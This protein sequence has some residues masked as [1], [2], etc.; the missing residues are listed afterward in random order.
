MTA[1]LTANITATSTPSTHLL[2]QLVLLGGGPAHVHLLAHL[3]RL[4]QNHWPGV[5]VTLVTPTQQLM[6]TG[7]LAGFVSGQRAL[8]DCVIPLEPL[9]QRSGMRW[10]AARAVELD[11]EAH[12]V[13]LDDNSVLHFDWLSLCNEPLQDRDVIERALPGARKNGLFVRPLDAFCALWP[14]VAELAASR[15]LRVAVIGGEIDEGMKGVNWVKGVNGVKQGAGRVGSGDAFAIELA[16]A[17]RHRLPGAAVTLITGG[18]PLATA[19]APAV[20]KRIARALRQRNVTVLADTATRILSGSI[21]LGCGA[22]LACDVP[23]IATV[24]QAPAWLANSGLALDAQGFIAVDAGQRCVS[25]ANI[26][27][28]GQPVAA[29]SADAADDDF[30]RAGQALV[31]GLEASL[32]AGATGGPARGTP[33]RRLLAQPPKLL[34]CCDGHAIA[35]WY[36]HGAQGRWVN[37]LKNRMDQSLV[38]RYRDI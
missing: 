2:K 21:L 3:G 38:A 11:A 33:G 20:Q 13:L 15:A 10:Q 26:F 5:Q 29:S 37:W 23:V 35:S 32:A 25:H 18:A 1:T 36:G 7:L 28:A 16:L 30:D 27:V 6:C 4:G 31:S 14:R 22:R 9:V 8:A 24:A 34:S 17:V 12:A 19:F